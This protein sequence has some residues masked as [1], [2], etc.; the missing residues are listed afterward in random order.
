MYIYNLAK[1][2]YFIISNA[3]LFWKLGSKRLLPFWEIVKSSKFHLFEDSV[4]Y[5]WNKKINLKKE[6][7]I[8]QN[9]PV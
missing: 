9:F 8:D 6:T 5:W 1:Q 4:T 7:M 2:G 3:S